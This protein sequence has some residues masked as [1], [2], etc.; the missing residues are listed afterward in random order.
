MNIKEA[1][2][3]KFFIS[4]YYFLITMIYYILIINLLCKEWFI[5]QKIIS[6][7][8]NHYIKNHNI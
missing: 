7:F 2:I 4:L 1:T 3:F 8:R 6:K 5:Q